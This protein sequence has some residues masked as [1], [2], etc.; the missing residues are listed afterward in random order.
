MALDV[1]WGSW[2]ALINF[3]D[4]TLEAIFHYLDQR[5]HSLDSRELCPALSKMNSSH[6]AS[7]CLWAVARALRVGIPARNE[8]RPEASPGTAPYSARK[9]ESRPSV[10]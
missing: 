2:R 9:P 5:D 6:I 1:R 7:Q 3:H 8:I 10:P 4:N